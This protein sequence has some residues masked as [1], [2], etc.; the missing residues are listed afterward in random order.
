LN[1]LT[2]PTPSLQSHY[3]T[4]ITTTSRPAPVPRIGTLPLTVIAA[5]GPPSRRHTDDEHPWNL[6]ASIETTGSPVPC[7]RL[8]R[9]HATYTPDTTRA[10]RRP[11][12]GWGATP[13]G[14]PLSRAMRAARFRCHQEPFDASAVVHTRSSSRRLPDPLV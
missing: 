7:Q 13:K 4:F 12:P 9:T 5:C 8:R 3:K 2:C 1:D 10:T 11:L 14:R 6:V